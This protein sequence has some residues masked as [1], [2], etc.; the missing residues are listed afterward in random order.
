MS[1]MRVKRIRIENKKESIK[2]FS[3][4]QYTS[5]RKNGRNRESWCDRTNL[6]R[7]HTCVI[8]RVRRPL[9]HSHGQRACWR[10]LWSIHFY[11]LKAASSFHSTIFL[12]SAL[13][14]SRLAA[15]GWA[16][17][18]HTR[19]SPGASSATARSSVYAKIERLY[20][21]VCQSLMRYEMSS[22]IH[23]FH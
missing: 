19:A 22:S 1:I 16:G 7:A 23:K 13:R 15:G 20:V 18:A 2:P 8:C 4:F 12:L 11:S 3:H 5:N 14:K 17:A 6:F 9:F 21:C 10:G